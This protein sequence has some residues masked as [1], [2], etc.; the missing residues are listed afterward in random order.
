MRRTALVLAMVVSLVVPAAV[1]AGNGSETGHY[2]WDGFEWTQT[3]SGWGPACFYGQDV[4]VAYTATNSWTYVLRDGDVRETLV[5]N[6]AAAVYDLDGNLVDTRPFHVTERFFDAGT[7]VAIRHDYP[8]SVWYEASHAWWS[9]DLE[10]Y[11]YIWKIPGVYDFRAW[12]DGGEYGWEFTPGECGYAAA[13]G[14]FPQIP[15]P[16][17]GRVP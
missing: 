16:F 10:S 2:S 12:N 9:A 6:G 17:N 15:H 8:D 7:D 3:Y 11:F 4:T 5:Q 14:R 13:A 1:A